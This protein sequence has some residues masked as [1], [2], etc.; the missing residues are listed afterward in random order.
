MLHLKGSKHEGGMMVG[1]C[2]RQLTVVLILLIS[3]IRTYL[4]CPGK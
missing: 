4:L 2:L 1:G 3:G